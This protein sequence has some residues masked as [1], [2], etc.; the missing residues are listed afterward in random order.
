M[1][2]VALWFPCVI[3]MTHVMRLTMPKLHRVTP[4]PGKLDDLPTVT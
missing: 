3:R 4:R 2:L 1:F